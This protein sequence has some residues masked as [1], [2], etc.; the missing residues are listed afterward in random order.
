M[1]ARREACVACYKD[2][3]TAWA[4]AATKVWSDNSPWRMTQ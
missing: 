1:P 2:K 3:N 4:S